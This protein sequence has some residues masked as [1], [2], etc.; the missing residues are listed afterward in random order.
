MARFPGDD[1]R[2][3]RMSIIEEGAEKKVAMAHLAV[4]GSHRLLNDYTAIVDAACTA[5]NRLAAE[6]GRITSLVSYPW[7]LKVKP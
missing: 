3:R 7:I 1:A 2:I 4:A 6:A 5:W